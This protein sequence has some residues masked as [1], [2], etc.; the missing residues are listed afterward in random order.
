MSEDFNEALATLEAALNDLF[1]QVVRIFR[2]REILDWLSER[3][4][5][6]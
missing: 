4:N 6:G 1:L 3:L 5:N 2:L